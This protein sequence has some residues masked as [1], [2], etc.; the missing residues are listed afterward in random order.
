[1][2]TSPAVLW[3]PQPKQAQALS[4]PAFELL[5][6]GAAG[7]GKSDFLLIDY[8]SGVNDWGA[9]WRGIIFRKSYAQL[10]G[11]VA[12]AKVLYMPIGARWKE[13]SKTF[14]FP[15]GAT[16]KFRF[17]MN[18]SDTEEYQGHEYTWIGF[19]EL[20]HH[21]SDYPWR[22]MMS[23]CRS[24]AGAPCYMRATAN[25]GGPGHGWI[26]NRFIDG[27]TPG[28]IHRLPDPE[29]GEGTT[30]CFIPALLEDN[31]I[32]M[33]MDPG[34]AQRMKLLPPHIYR[35]LRFG[36]WD[37]FSGQVFSEWRREL[38]VCRPFVLSPGEWF[39]FYSLDWGFAKPFSIGKW[40]VN[41]EGRMV[42]YGEWYGCAKDEL[43]T[44]I[45]MSAADVAAKAFSEALKEGVSQMVADPAC[46]SRSGTGPSV[47]DFFKDRG[48]KMTPADNDRKNGLAIFHQRMIS[49]G[50]DDRPMLLVFDICL[51]FIRTIPTLTPD[52][53]DSEDVD[54]DL[55]DHIYDEGRYALMSQF[56]RNPK[57][58][59][60]RQNGDWT[61]GKAKAYDPLSWSP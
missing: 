30:R 43:N 22:Y 17:L 37:V 32:L 18:N 28:R 3:E 36:D 13:Q 34:Y 14:I 35:A 44:G 11:L 48:F 50:E 58:A 9:N 19:D 53:N 51:D 23:R 59:L 54:T 16:I 38:H 47:A 61:F 27:F 40:A 56:A 4:C 45:K 1:M 57:N 7:G 29:G 10:E 31:P 46:W 49:R 60:R 33:Q 21:A 39:K 42:R 52:Q 15:N 25:P 5:Y 41:R 26:K 24:S 55:E 6:G 20:G 12:R 2:K 8:L